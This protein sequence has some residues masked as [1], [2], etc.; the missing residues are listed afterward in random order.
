MFEFIHLFRKYL[1]SV[2]C[3]LGTVV[4]AGDTAV[5]IVGGG[6]GLHGACSVIGKAENKVNSK[7][8]SI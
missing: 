7:L 2:D 1:L 3:S 5:N 4:G 8:E 6:P